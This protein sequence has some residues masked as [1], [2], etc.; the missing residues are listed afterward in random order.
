VIALKY[1]G[2]RVVPDSEGFPIIPGRRGRVEYHDG[3][4]LAVYSDRARL[5]AQ[6]WAIPGVRRW[7]VG[8]REARGLFLAETLPAVAAV[9]RARRRRTLSSEAARQ[10]GAATAYRATSATQ[11]LA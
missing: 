11:E 5:F 3:T 6:L 1:G 8:D 2:L 4:E 10:R 9:I 7:Q